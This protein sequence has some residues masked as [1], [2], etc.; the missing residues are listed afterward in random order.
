MLVFN[1]E[2]FSRDYEMQKWVS[3][4]EILAYL[5]LRE[6]WISSISTNI[7]ILLIYLYFRYIEMR[8]AANK[9]SAD[10]ETAKGRDEEAA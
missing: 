2:D 1:H 10:T 7:Y 4:T 6:G 8:F 3:V 9:I 5:F